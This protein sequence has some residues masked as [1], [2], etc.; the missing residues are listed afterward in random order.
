MGFV[1]NPTSQMKF[2]IE[3]M[4]SLTWWKGSSKCMPC[5]LASSPSMW[6]E[7]RRSRQLNGLLKQNCNNTPEPLAHNPKLQPFLEAASI[8][9]STPCMNCWCIPQYGLHTN[10]KR[11]LILIQPVTVCQAKM[12]HVKLSSTCRGASLLNALQ[13]CEELFLIFG[14]SL[15]G[16]L[17]IKASTSC[18]SPPLINMIPTFWQLWLC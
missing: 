17:L 9:V 7:E 1:L 8:H 2:L 13:F 14:I 6:L 10:H 3:R 4:I 16:H 11:W 18:I 12:L 15:Q 5:M